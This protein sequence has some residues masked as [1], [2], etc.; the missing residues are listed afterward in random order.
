MWTVSV[1]FVSTLLFTVNHTKKRYQNV[2]HT[3]VRI[4][5]DSEILGH[6]VSCFYSQI[7]QKCVDREEG[8]IFNICFEL[9]IVL[10]ES[11]SFHKS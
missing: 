7:R 10:Y 3:A 9:N 5:H 6:G 2:I 4:Y 11:S 8:K 1:Q